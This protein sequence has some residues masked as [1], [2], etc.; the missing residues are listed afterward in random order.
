MIN[1]PALTNGTDKQIAYAAKIRDAVIVEVKI[2]A[3]GHKASGITPEAMFGK[4]L[5]MI[6]AKATTDAVAWIE[7]Y[8]AASSF[9]TDDGGCY[10]YA[11]IVKAVM[12]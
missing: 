8:N 5:G 11:P 7:A 3:R 9:I 10:N 6:A 12:A 2:S 1:L 4:H